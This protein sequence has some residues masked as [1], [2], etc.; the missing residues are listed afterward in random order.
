MD[1]E[2]KNTYKKWRTNVDT[3]SHIQAHSITELIEVGQVHGQL[4]FMAA[5]QQ[6]DHAEF[7]AIC[8]LQFGH[9][10]HSLPNL[11]RRPLIVRYR[12]LSSQNPM[13]NVT[14]VLDSFH[15]PL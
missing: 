9:P 15:S 14:V 5:I 7:K 3:N 12:S 2:N 4:G 8:F 10:F 1:Q 13:T 11:E 6:L